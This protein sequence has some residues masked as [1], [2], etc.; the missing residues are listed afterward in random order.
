MPKDFDLNSRE[1][2]ALVFADKN[3]EYG[4]YVTRD[5]SSDRHLKA[6]A[7]ITVVALG[8][9]FLPGLIKSV[10]PVKEDV[11][12]IVDVNLTNLET[13]QELPEENQIQQIEAPPPP[14]LKATVA[15]TPPVITKDENIRDDEL[16]KTQQELTETKA[17]IS[18]ATVEGVE[19]GTVDIVDVMEKKVIIEEGVT[20]IGSNAFWGV[21]NM[22]DLTIANTVTTIGY[23]SFF[24]CLAL[25]ELTI[26]TSVTHISS[27]A[28]SNC[29]A[30][31]EVTVPN[32]VKTL[33]INIFEYCSKLT[34]IKVDVANSAY[35]S[36]NGVLFDKAQTALVAYPAG[37]QGVYSIP[38]T[39]TSI[40]YASF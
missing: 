2:L 14:E 4:A 32:S 10:M 5:E 30:L 24:S 12:Q 28:F 31:T 37:K 36:V 16:I 40:D 1:W 19:G 35:S 18:V 11:G 39:V 26:P 27:G 25:A 9:F 29:H 38:N 3:K 17:D 34:A 21:R 15:F 20:S 33:G 22:T 6:I 8:L 13:L 7:I 23:Q